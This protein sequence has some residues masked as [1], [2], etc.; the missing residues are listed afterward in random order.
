MPPFDPKDL[1]VLARAFERALEVLP[2]SGLDPET[3]KLVLVTAIMD[4]AG[5]GERDEGRLTEFALSAIELYKK[6][7]MAAVPRVASL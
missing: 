1:D 5:R 6:G 3:T 4:V 7:D 2:A